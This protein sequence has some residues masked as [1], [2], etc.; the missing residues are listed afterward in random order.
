M[1]KWQH[2]RKKPHTSVQNTG[3]NYISPLF[4]DLNRQIDKGMKHYTVL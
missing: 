2:T 1:P 4:P 3:L